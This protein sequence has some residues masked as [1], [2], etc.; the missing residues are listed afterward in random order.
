LKFTIPATG[1]KSVRGIVYTTINDSSICKVS[2][3][4]G[5]G[6]ED[7]V[8]LHGR[9]CM[10]LWASREDLLV[11]CG[12]VLYLV[13]GNEAKPVLRAKAGNWFW[14]AV[15]GDGKV[16]VHEYGES[17]TGIYVTEDLKS[18]RKASTNLDIDPWSRHFHY[19][20]FDDS[21]G[22]LVATLGDSNIVRAAVSQ[23]HGHTYRPLYKGPWQ[24]VPVLIDGDKWI[25]GFDSGIARGGVGVYDTKR[26]ELSFTFLRPSSHKN[27]Q[28]ASLKRF[29]DCYIGCLGYPT[30]IVA[31]RDLR[32][33]HLLYVDNSITGYNHFVDVEPWNGKIVAVTGRELLIIES[34][35]IEKTFEE[36]PFL[37]PYEVCLDRLK[38]LAF[39]IKRIRWM[40]KT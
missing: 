13:S 5:G 20:A 16:F 3:F 14:H 17:P 15:E 34:N 36:K 31:S 11:S 37:T 28:F 32:H 7:V 23:D 35:N 10:L 9:P 18:F 22:L 8:S 26:G 19:L 29:G 39:T 21:R 30:A 6:M 40:L 1:I 4:K 24:F 27:A 38:G 12:E 33:W 2:V 25:F